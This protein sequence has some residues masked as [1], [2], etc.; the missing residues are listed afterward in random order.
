MIVRRGVIA[1]YFTLLLGMEGCAPS[2]PHD[3]VQRANAAYEAVSARSESMLIELSIA[4]RRT[5]IRTLANGGAPRDGDIIIPT[6]FDP[7]TAAYFSTIG[8]PVLTTSV[9]RSLGIVGDYFKLLATLADGRNV[10]EAKAQINSLA[11]S[12]AGVV[13]LATG[14]TALPIVA[15][16]DKLT[17]LI[18]Q[19]AEAKDAEE[20]RRLVLEGEPIVKSLIASL[21]SASVTMYET[22]TRESMRAVRTTLAD[23]PAARHTAFVQMAESNILVAD[24]VVLLGKLSDTLSALASAVRSPESPLALS[25]LAASAD[26]VLIQARAA[27][28]AIALIKAGRA[29]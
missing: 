2:I 25:S 4:E 29:P 20:L 1:A 11:A 14:G 9:R 18:E 13:T 10:D 3:Q 22:L 12:V 17:P 28:G 26:S 16:A 21:Q 15:I 5:Y 23:N 24:Y 6:T 19:W 8:D 27:S 7:K